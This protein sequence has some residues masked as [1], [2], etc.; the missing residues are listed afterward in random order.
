MNGDRKTYAEELRH[1]RWQ[2]RRLRVFEQAGFRC[3]RCG[4][5]DKQLHAHHKTYIKGRRPW[6]YADDLLE[7]LCDTCHTLAHAELDTLRVVIAQQPTAIGATLIRLVP[8][9]TAIREADSAAEY[10]SACNRLQDELD[11]QK[12]LGRGSGV[13][14]DRACICDQLKQQMTPDKWSD[15][16]FHADGHHGDCPA[17]DPEFCEEGWQ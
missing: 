16:T 15:Q 11:A 14:A 5:D 8:M 1:P 3:E 9:L 12:D 6:E 13:P 17:A 10:V 4:C 7:C 2:E